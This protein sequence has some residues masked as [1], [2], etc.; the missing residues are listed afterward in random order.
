MSDLRTELFTKVIPK[1]N[2]LTKPTELNNL[3]FDDPE[4]PLEVAPEIL[5]NNELIFNYVKEHP[6]CY[7]ADVAK[8]F[9]GRISTSSVLSQIH[10][11]ARRE[12]FHKVKCSTTG[13]LM[14]STA[15]DAYP[16]AKGTERTA[17][18]L[19]AMATMTPE[20]RGARIKEG[21]RKAKL[22]QAEQQLAP[23]KKIVLIKKDTQEQVVPRPAGINI[24]LLPLS[25]A[26][27]LYDEL[28]KVFGG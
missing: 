22:K 20:E 26:R 11:M 2:A 13:Y 6:A 10:T 19:K 16:R 12:L 18:L 27:R 24:D 21:H 28:R 5:S 1:M 14:Y 4:Q 15:V 9:N 7:G 3:N 8:H 25:E 23:T 17:R